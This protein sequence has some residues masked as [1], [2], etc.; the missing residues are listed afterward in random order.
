MAIDSEDKRRSAQYG[1]PGGTVRPIADGSIGTQDR[2]HCIWLYRGLSY[3]APVITEGGNI[4]R[5]FFSDKFLAG[6]KKRFS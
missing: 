3:S 4:F 2:P 1:T 5:R 6:F